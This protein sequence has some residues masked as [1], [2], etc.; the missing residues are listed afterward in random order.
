M[1][2]VFPTRLKRKLLG[3]GRSLRTQRTSMSH[4]PHVIGVSSFSFISIVFMEI[5]I[6]LNLLRICTSCTVWAYG[7]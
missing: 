1:L 6:T 7:F 2:V 4:M 3:N 5:N